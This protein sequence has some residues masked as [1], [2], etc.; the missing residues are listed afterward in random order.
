M[1]VKNI[2]HTHTHSH[3]NIQ[4]RKSQLILNEECLLLLNA[5][6][7]AVSIFFASLISHNCWHTHSQFVR[8]VPHFDK[9]L[10][11]SRITVNKKNSEQND[12][13]LWKNTE[14]NFEREKHH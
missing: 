8:N 12:N 6:D 11:D 10:H 7:A 3:T 2:K 14:K 5:T 9:Y 13:V 4:T 1:Y